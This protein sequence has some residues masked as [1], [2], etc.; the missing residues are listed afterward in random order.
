MNGKNYALL[1]SFLSW[2]SLLAVNWL[3]MLNIIEY[4]GLRSF[5][6][7]GIF[8]MIGFFAAAVGSEGNK[9]K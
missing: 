9:D 3:Q 7:I 1:L 4:D 5:V 2:L 8:A 6:H